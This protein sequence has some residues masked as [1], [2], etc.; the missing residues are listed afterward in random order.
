MFSNTLYNLANTANQYFVFKIGFFADDSTQ[1]FYCLKYVYCLSSLSG[2]V[3]G[4][5]LSPLNRKE[6]GSDKAEERSVPCQVLI[7]VGR[8]HKSPDLKIT[9]RN[10][11]VFGEGGDAP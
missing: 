10:L 4:A 11:R 5:G 3:F 2:G 6:L 1:F 7:P 9:E 8:T